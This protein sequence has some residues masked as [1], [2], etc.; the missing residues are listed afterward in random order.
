ME[1]QRQLL[2]L[3]PGTLHVSF[4]L[5]PLSNLVTYSY[6]ILNGRKKCAQ[7]LPEERLRYRIWFRNRTRLKYS[8]F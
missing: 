4:P 1:E 5:F 8:E 6:R 2:T 7:L 3:I